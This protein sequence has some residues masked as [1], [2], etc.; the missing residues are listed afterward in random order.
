[1]N[2]DWYYGIWTVA[3][4]LL[5]MQQLET[6]DKHHTETNILCRYGKINI[7][8]QNIGSSLFHAIYSQ[9]FMA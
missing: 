8:Q 4:S 1:M 3:V 2:L 6:L 5:E 9:I 7:S